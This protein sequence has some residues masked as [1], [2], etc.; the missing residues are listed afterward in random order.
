M[1][2]FLTRKAMLQYYIFVGTLLSTTLVNVPGML[3]YAQ[4]AGMCVQPGWL[5]A[6]WQSK[7]WGMFALAIYFT[8]VWAIG[9]S[10]S[11]GVF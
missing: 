4:I 9:L 5:Y 6:G 8:F 3:L 11:L 2:K 1:K 10:N 7:Q